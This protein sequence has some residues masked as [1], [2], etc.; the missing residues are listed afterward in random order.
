MIYLTIGL[1]LI[2]SMLAMLDW[3]RGLAL[4]VLVGVAQDPL[5]K[6]T[7]GQPLYYV[8]LVGVVFGA[9]WIRAYTRGVQLSPLAIYGWR[10]QLKRPFYALVI[11]VAAQA[12]HSLLTYRSITVTGIGLLVWLAPAPAV[13]LAYQ[14]AMRRGL[15]G[16]HRWMRI[17]ITL[18]LLSLSGVYL[19]YAGLQ[20]PVL[21]EVGA[22]LVIYDVGT[23]LKAY[24]GFYRSSE[25][26]AW[27]TAAIA[28]FIFILSVGKRATLARVAAA[29]AL[30]TLLAGLGLLT[31]RRKMLVEITV[32]LSIYFFLTSWLQ[33]GAAKL[34]VSLLLGGA[35]GY[36]AIVG[37]ISPDLTQRPGRTTE[38]ST[39]NAQRIRGYAERGQ[40]VFAEVPTRINALGVQPVLWAVQ[41]HGWLGAG[42]GTGSQGAQDI[43]ELHTLSRGASEGGLG[44]ITMELGVPGL[45]IVVWMLYALGK[46]VARQLAV[47]TRLSPQH[48][49]MSY[50]LVAFLLANAAT[51]AVATQAYSDLF[52]LLMLGWTLGFLL[53][54]PALA[55]RGD[56]RKQGFSETMPATTMPMPMPMHLAPDSGPHGFGPLAPQ[57]VAR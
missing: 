36:V 33:R 52:A 10:K 38:L 41:M 14:F 19:Q 30:I 25:I 16:V 4:C 17:Y 1:L 23:V 26:A 3:R 24:S 57:P 15:A 18:A 2:A 43:A 8:V 11:L 21:G 28:C 39:E 48:A 29:L 20:W 45:F 35:L 5:R 42:L 9:A 47:L 31:G 7:A 12:M 13:V 46:H 44:K 55:A 53:A 27:H 34:A 37:F 40:T 6:L 22:G 54:M 51:F 50:G 32:F 49:R 56:G